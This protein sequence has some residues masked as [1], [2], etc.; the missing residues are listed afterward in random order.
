MR[1]D[2]I[3]NNESERDIEKF[4]KYEHYEQKSQNTTRKMKDKPIRLDGIKRENVKGENL[5]NDLYA[6]YQKAEAMRSQAEQQPGSRRPSL[7]KGSNTMTTFKDEVGNIKVSDDPEAREKFE[8]L[9]PSKSVRKLERIER[10]LKVDDIKDMNG[11]LK[12]IELRI[13]GRVTHEIFMG[14]VEDIEEKL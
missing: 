10:R 8:R 1:L 14:F 9:K 11:V 12:E 2:K 3:F 7:L 5:K 6:E 13:E 4:E